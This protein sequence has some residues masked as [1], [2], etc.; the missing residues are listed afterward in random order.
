VPPW[1][2][3]ASMNATMLLVWSKT[4]K[5]VSS[6]HLTARHPHKGFALLLSNLWDRCKSMRLMW[7]A[8]ALYLPGMANF[9]AGGSLQSTFC[10]N[11][12]R[13]PAAAPRLYPIILVRMFLSDVGSR[14]SVSH[15]FAFDGCWVIVAV[16]PTLLVGCCFGTGCI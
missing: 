16:R 10:C 12:S 2:L 15:V 6:T 4:L 5:T 7:L 9:G 14:K 3:P 11:F 1:L 13:R 8:N